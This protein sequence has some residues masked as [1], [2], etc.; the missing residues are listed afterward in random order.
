VVIYGTSDML[1]KMLK[2]MYILLGFV[3]T[4]K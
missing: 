1:F 3:Y 4:C 2:K